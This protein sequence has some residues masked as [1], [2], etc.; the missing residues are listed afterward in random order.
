MGARAAHVAAQLNARFHAG[1]PSNDLAAA[2]LLVHQFDGYDTEDKFM[3]P[4]RPCASC[5]PGECRKCIETSDRLS[6]AIIYR[7]MTADP[8]TRLDVKAHARGALP[9][10]SRGTA[11]LIL[12]PTANQLLCAYPYDGGSGGKLCSPLGVSAHCV[13]GC[14]QRGEDWCTEAKR[15]AE[16]AWA[17]SHLKDALVLR[18]QLRQ[19]PWNWLDGSRRTGGVAGGVGRTRAMSLSQPPNSRPD[20]YYAEAIVEAATFK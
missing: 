8:L 7:N 20:S 13:P 9:L 3:P 5:A 6:A 14:T 1:H 12:S 4:W 15:G 17:P 16:C 19:R 2:G 18:E 10:Y 11:G